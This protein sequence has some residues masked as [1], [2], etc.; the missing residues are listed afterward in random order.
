MSQERML[1]IKIFQALGLDLSLHHETFFRREDAD[2]QLFITFKLAKVINKEDL[3]YREF[4]Y[5]KTSKAGKV[6]TISGERLCIQPW[7]FLTK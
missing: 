6:D 4:W 5:L 3:Q 2:G 7:R 1:N